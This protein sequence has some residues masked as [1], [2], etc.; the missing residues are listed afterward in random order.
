MNAMAPPT[1]TPRIAWIDAGL[2][3][4]AAGGPDAL[5]IEPLA[6]ALGVTRGGF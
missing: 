4:L 5:R 2:S 1:R 3:A 6:Q